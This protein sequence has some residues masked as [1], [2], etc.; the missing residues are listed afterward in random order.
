MYNG[1]M[2]YDDDLFEQLSKISW[3]DLFDIVS[4]IE[5]EHEQTQ[6]NYRYW[7]SPKRRSIQ[8]DYVNINKV[9]FKIIKR[10]CIRNSI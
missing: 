8:K 10:P 3:G 5:E 1:C 2:L 7:F 9:A 6:Y 4:C